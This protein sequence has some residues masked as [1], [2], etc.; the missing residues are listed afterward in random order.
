MNLFFSL[1]VNG[2]HQTINA[3]RTYRLQHKRTAHRA[4]LCINA[5]CFWRKG[6]VV[7]NICLTRRSRLSLTRRKP[8][9]GRRRRAVFHGPRH[10]NLPLETN[11]ALLIPYLQSHVEG[12]DP[13]SDADAEGGVE[14]SSVL[15]RPDVLFR[16]LPPKQARAAPSRGFQEAQDCS[17]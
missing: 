13:P 3:T 12:A 17:E 11:N 4:S 10:P 6:L 2:P 5:A 15:T 8:P 1:P 9:Q 7:F 14:E 16:C